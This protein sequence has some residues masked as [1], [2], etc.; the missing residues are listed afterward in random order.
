MTQITTPRVLFISLAMILLGSLASTQPA[1]HTLMRDHGVSLPERGFEGAF[2]DNEDPIIAPTPGAF[3]VPLAMMTASTGK[4]RI[5]AAYAFGILAARSGANAAPAER[6]A[7]AQALIRMILSDDRKAR[8][9]G[10]R[11]AGR[12]L[13]VPLEVAPRQG[14]GQAHVPAPPVGLVASLFALFNRDS[15]TEQLAA[16]DALGLIRE[17]AAV[18]ALTERYYFYRDAKQRALAG[19]AIEA[20]ARIAD[21]S[22]ADV[23][24]GLAGDRWAEGK[25][26]TALAVAFARERLLKDGSIAIIQRAL[27]D[28]S[29][30]VQAS[31]YLAELGVPIP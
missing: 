14:S 31:G 9:A 4:D 28:Q 17:R 19:G 29:R 10:A 1:L 16:M 8:I 12:V 6:A 21:P 13:A 18:P 26:P 3:A 24:K 15:E 22:T 23:V 25:D 27:D 2:D 11:V 20:L 30:R 7:A 5:A